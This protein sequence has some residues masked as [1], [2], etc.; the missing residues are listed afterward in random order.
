MASWEQGDLLQIA[1]CA[2]ILTSFWK[3][4]LGSEALSSEDSAL[5]ASPAQTKELRAL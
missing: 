2:G 5:L 1:S 4:E 3:R